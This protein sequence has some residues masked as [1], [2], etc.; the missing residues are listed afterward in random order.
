MA[1][2]IAIVSLYLL[3][4]GMLLTGTLNTIF[5]KL[6]NGQKYHNNE[7]DEEVQ[8]N[9]PFFQTFCMFVGELLCM[10][11]YGFNYYQ[12]KKK[13]G[14]V[15]TSPQMVSLRIIPQHILHL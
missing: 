8:Y 4:L 9:H 5:L 12:D 11:V 2:K 3:M 7:K 13:Y 10:G 15:L 1:E 14:D 6:Q